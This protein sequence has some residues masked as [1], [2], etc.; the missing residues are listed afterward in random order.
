MFLG[1]DGGG[2]K[3]A[4]VLIDAEGQILATHQESTCYHVQVG[5]DGAKA[6]LY[7]GVT[8][9][10]TKAGLNIDSVS[11]AFFG[12]PAFGED[13]ELDPKLALLPAQL[14]PQQKFQCDN[15]MVNAWA[16]AF[17]AKDGINMIAGTGSIAYGMR[18]GKS[19]RCGGWGELFSDEG[20]AYW[21]GC[22]GLMLFSRMSDGRDDK[23]PLYYTLKRT[24][25]ITHDLD[26]SALVLSK[27]KGERSRIAQV[28]TLVYEAA[29]EGDKLAK[30]IFTRA[31]REL[32]EIVEGTRKS[33]GYEPEEI[34]H[35]G[36]SGGAFSASELILT[37][38]VEALKHFSNGY[39]VQKPLYSPD[40][41]AAIY[42]ARLA[43]QPLS[44]LA[45]NRLKKQ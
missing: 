42:A 13:S 34:V 41:G 36:F 38:F 43:G 9:L 35:V 19:A 33:L 24:Y 3:T 14:I 16:A 45:L 15:D 1:V 27:W 31:G 10:F 39:F 20:S 28:S 18:K 12:L 32:A 44:E 21:I 23:G 2:T 25:G 5:L 11:Y 17:G 8:A 6:V 4:F 22:K 37:P 40:V 7:N 26:M 29:L 30:G